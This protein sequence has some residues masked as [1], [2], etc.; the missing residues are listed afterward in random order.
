M[1]FEYNGITCEAQTGAKSGQI[2]E[3]HSNSFLSL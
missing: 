3:K 1:S 2:F